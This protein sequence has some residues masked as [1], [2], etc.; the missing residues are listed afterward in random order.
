MP[1]AEMF[2]VFSHEGVLRVCNSIICNGTVMHDSK[3][4]LGVE[5]AVNTTSPSDCG[6]DS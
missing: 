3:I 1:S 2:S 5:N 6:G 4:P